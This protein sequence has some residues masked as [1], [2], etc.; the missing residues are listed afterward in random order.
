MV[1]GEFKDRMVRRFE[2]V[3]FETLSTYFDYLDGSLATELKNV[4]KI[5]F[6]KFASPSKK[7]KL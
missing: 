5:E 7:K 6:K 2:M 3:V 4:P 1:E